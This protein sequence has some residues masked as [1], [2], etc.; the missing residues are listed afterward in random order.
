MQNIMFSYACITCCFSLSGDI[1]ISEGYE[2]LF[3]NQPDFIN[4]GT[5]ILTVEVVHGSSSSVLGLTECL[6][7]NNRFVTQIEVNIEDGR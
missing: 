3:S 1:D 6:M 2:S 4:H 7:D 5:R